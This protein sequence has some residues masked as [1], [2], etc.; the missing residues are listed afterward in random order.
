[1]RCQ[2]THTGA[3]V[4]SASLQK[5]GLQLLTRRNKSKSGSFGWRFSSTTPAPTNSARNSM[6]SRCR[7][8]GGADELGL[9]H[10]MPPDLPTN[11]LIRLHATPN[12][13]RDHEDCEMGGAR[14]QL[15]V[16]PIG[17]RPRK[18]VRCLQVAHLSHLGLHKSQNGALE[19]VAGARLWQ[20][21]RCA[22]PP[23]FPDPDPDYI[24]SPPSQQDS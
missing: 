10:S 22:L 1:M 6:T 14:A 19:G 20:A 8:C 5:P 4:H 3:V 23:A 24:S 2:I 7:C 17:Q 12:F 9:I 13:K 11:A 18:A 16:G 21:Q 15:P